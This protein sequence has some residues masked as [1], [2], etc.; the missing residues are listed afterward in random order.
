M[1]LFWYTQWDGFTKE[2]GIWIVKQNDSLYVCYTL[3][4]CTVS[5]MCW[6]LITAYSY[7]LFPYTSN[8]M[9]NNIIMVTWTLNLQT[10]CTMGTQP[11]VGFMLLC[12]MLLQK[13]LTRKKLCHGQLAKYAVETC[14]MHNTSTWLHILY[15]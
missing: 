9:Y 6:H 13:Q 1:Y 2:Q 7:I 10:H 4:A 12:A 5:S 11:Y 14:L 8:T 15:T 3:T